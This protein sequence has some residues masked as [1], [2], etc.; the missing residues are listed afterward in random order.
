MKHLFLTC[1]AGLCSF[2][3]TTAQ[4]PEEL[5]SY[6]PDIPVFRISNDI[7][8]FN[9]DN[10]FN[11]INGAAPLFLAYNFKEM[12]SMEYDDGE[13]SITIQ[14]YRHDTP[15]DAFGMYA[16]ER[17]DN[18]EYFDIGGEAQG[19]NNGLYFFAGCIY[20][21]MS[22]NA[23]AEADGVGNTMREIGKALAEKI[24][25]DATYPPL[26]TRFPL[27]NKISYSEYYTNAGYIGHSFLNHVYS[28]N[29]MNN[30]LQY[31]LFLIDGNTPDEAKAII[32]KYLEFAKQSETIAEGEIFIIHDR[33]NGDIPCLW[34]GQYIYG[35]FSENGDTLNPDLL[36][37]FE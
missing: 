11:R 25:A 36:N 1:I 27:E 3:I 33:Y 22:S 10:L 21:K 18:L 8:V 30:E 17:S 12:T 14:A 37:T 16:S 34:K 35:A 23:D 29:Y 19:D 28:C 24:N 6:L 5:R 7:E 15:A 32:D 9:A 4:S 2:T 13:N 26:F 20:V 31:Q